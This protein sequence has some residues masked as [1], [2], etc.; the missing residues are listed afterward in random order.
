MQFLTANSRLPRVIQL[1][2]VLVEIERAF[3]IQGFQ[4]ISG[5]FSFCTH[6]LIELNKVGRVIIRLLSS[7]NYSC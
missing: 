3:W 5:T 4:E 1:N 7:Y 6:G 2:E